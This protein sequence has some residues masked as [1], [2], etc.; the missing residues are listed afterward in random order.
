MLFK[1]IFKKNSIISKKSWGIRII[2]ENIVRAFIKQNGI[3]LWKY[4]IVIDMQHNIHARH[5]YTQIFGETDV[6]PNNEAVADC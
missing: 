6:G 3:P 2:T 5:D 4:L 1:K